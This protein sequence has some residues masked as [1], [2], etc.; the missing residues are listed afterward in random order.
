MSLYLSV[1]IAGCLSLEVVSGPSRGLR[2]CVQS[3]D[4]SKLP[5]MLGRV[6]PS[7]LLLKDSEV[8]GKHA[9]I[10]W[11]SDVTLMKTITC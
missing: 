3:T 7:V 11:N 8:S 2:C 6:S 9:Q 4:D 10:N 5:L 1:R